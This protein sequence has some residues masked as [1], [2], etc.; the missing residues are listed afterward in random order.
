VSD[1]GEQNLSNG[2]DVLSCVVYGAGGVFIV[3]VV[4]ACAAPLACSAHNIYDVINLGKACTFL[5][6]QYVPEAGMLR[7]AY[8]PWTDDYGR[9]Y[10]NDN[11]LAVKALTICGDSKLASIVSSTL[12]SKYGRYLRSGRHEVLVNEPIP[13]TP[14]VRTNVVLG[15]V[16]DV[17]VVAEIAGN[18]T[19]SDWRVYADWLLLESIN[20]IIKGDEVRARKLFRD[21]MLMWDGMG[22]RDKAVE[23]TGQYDT[24][25]LALAIY[26]FKALGEPSSYENQVKE[27]LSII[28]RAQDPISGGIHTNYIL[29]NGTPY[30]NVSDSNVETTSMVII[31][32]YGDRPKSINAGQVMKVQPLRFYVLVVVL[33][34]VTIGIII[35]TIKQAKSLEVHHIV[36]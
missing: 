3:A 5:R 4:L 13:D 28:A 24:Y 8:S 30:F 15:H 22:L 33:I 25:K 10:I 11:V 34:I 1:W 14:L 35:I 32:L 9:I 29:H 26:A 6:N 19:L 7:A 2:E 27:M 20:S 36:L 16:G 21:A 23:T 31:A 12:T 17:V 18:S